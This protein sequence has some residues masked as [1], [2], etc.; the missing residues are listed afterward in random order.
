MAASVPVACS[1]IDV[2]REVAGDCAMYFDAD[3]DDD[4][5]R[6]LREILSGQCKKIEDARQH[7]AEFRWEDTARKTLAV[8]ARAADRTAT[9]LTDI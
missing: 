4:M 6:A 8:L 3:N 1:A 9:N 5:E 7:A 2:L